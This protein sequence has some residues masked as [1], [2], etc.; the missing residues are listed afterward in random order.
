MWRGSGRRHS[1][2]T[3][4]VAQPP[5]PHPWR[6]SINDGTLYHIIQWNVGNPTRIGLSNQDLLLTLAVI[7]YEILNDKRTG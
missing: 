6:L 3:R 4:L 7:I 5:N 2:D 1:P